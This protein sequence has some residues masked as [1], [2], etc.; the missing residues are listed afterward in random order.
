VDAEIE[1]AQVRSI[2]AQTTAAYVS[3]A[4]VGVLVYAAVALGYY[5]FE[6]GFL[7]GTAAS[8]VVWLGVPAPI[9]C[10]SVVGSLTS[11][12]LRAGQFLFAT[13]VDA[14]KWVLFRPIVGVVMGMMGYL[15]IRAGLIVFAGGASPTTEELLW[16]LAF[17]GA[18]S[19]TWSVALLQKLLGQFQHVKAAEPAGS[20]VA[21][22]AGIT[23]PVPREG[24]APPST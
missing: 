16:L 6:S 9:W 19:D 10:W 2:L 23:A 17:A 15:M 4:V 14:L 11:M 13:P 3:L 18:F 21:D 12:L 22:V 8:T 5:G 7:S 1:L 24:G 20:N